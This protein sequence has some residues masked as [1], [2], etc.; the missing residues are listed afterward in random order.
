LL[1]G[2]VV[3]DLILRHVD[4]DDAQAKLGDILLKF[5]TVV[6]LLVDRSGLVIGK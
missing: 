6:V 1:D 5:Y 3:R 2:F 4:Y